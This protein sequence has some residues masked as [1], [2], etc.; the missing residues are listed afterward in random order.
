MTKTDL[1][2]GFRSLGLGKGMKVMVHSS[3]SSFGYV[4]GGADTVIDALM[5]VLTE[6]G[7][8]MM[9]S[10][11][12]EAP[13]RAGKIYDVHETPTT[14][15]IIPDT[16]WRRQGVYRSINPTHAFAAWGKN[17]AY[18]TMD[19]RKSSA[20]GEDSPLDRLKKDGG[21][22]LLLGVDYTRNTFHHHVETC[23]GAPCL[24]A[25]G[26]E[27]PVRLY[28]GSEVMAHTWSWRDGSCPIDDCAAY[29]P[30]MAAID[31]KARIGGAVCTLYKLSEGYDIIAKALREGLG[32]AL[33]CGQ[34]PIRPRVC[35]WTVPDRENPVT[36]RTIRPS[37]ASDLAALCAVSLGYN[38]GAAIVSQKIAGLQKSREVVYGADD[39]SGKI[40]GFVHAEIYD[41][42]Y[43]E[44]AVNI[45]GLAVLPDCRRKG[46]GTSLMHAVEAWA[47]AHDIRLIRLNS[48]GTRHDAHA[49]Y[50]SIG[51]ADEKAQLRFMKEL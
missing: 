11:N 29:A 10:F 41:T 17:A 12:H 16:F 2:D 37:D 39:G 28:D 13:Y 21:Y 45:L 5:E 31:R 33:P 6:E 14:N 42:L 34:C 25:R 26:E 43:Y 48:G 3:L 9:P 23:E 51:F 8:L 47:K 36:I 40:I 35:R 20:M 49:F 46:V 44:T 38:A 50:R 19:H 32:N 15:G 18:Y 24:R 1:T 27:Y 30:L 7:T 4:E 22:C